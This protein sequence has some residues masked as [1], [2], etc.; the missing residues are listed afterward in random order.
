MTRQA[1]IVQVFVASPSDVQR[2]RDVLESLITELNQTWSRSLGVTFELVRWET[3]VRPALSTDPQAV[4]NEQIGDD[5]D[6][7][8]GILWGRFGTPT[9]R[10]MSGTVEEFDRAYSRFKKQGSP[11][12]MFYFK[13]TPMQPSRI[14]PVQLNLVQ[15]FRASLYDKGIYSTFEDELGFQTSLRAHLAALAQKFS[16]AIPRTSERTPLV[17]APTELENVVADDLGYLD[18]VELYQSRMADL[19]ATIEIITDATVRV[20]QQMNQRTEEV[21]E[22]SKKPLDTATARRLVKRAADDMG[23]YA[24]I[25]EK[26]L[27]LMTSYREAA[28]Q[29]LTK[30]LTLHQEFGQTDK[31]D[32]KSLRTGLKTMLDTSRG[33]RAGLGGFRDS[34]DRL[35]RMTGD[36][37]RAKSAVLNQLNIMLSELDSTGHNIGNI[38]ES[39]DAIIG[40]E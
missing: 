14:D 35:P 23:A 34:V 25:L 9:P 24:G 17:P 39:I 27:P 28:L 15:K 36:L 37:N 6:V 10:A 16:T 29:A 22:L 7:F 20:G 3:H 18:Y 38:M 19:T 40:D 8:I 4:V 33:A 2:E 12:V 21:N 31:S 5:Y 13:D 32:L 30:A 11:E 26:Q 1:T